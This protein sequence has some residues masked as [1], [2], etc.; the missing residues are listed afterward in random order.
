MKGGRFMDINIIGYW[1]EKKE[2]LKNKYSN[3]NDEDL[4]FSDSK[5]KEMIELLGYKL[6]ISK[7]ELC[8]IIEDL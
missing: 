1:N 2:K 7:F 3:I 5:E 8:K 6:S 4:C